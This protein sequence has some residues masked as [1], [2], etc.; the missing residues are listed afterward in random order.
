MIPACKVFIDGINK[1]SAFFD[2][3]GACLS[4]LKDDIS[5]T[6]E[7]TRKFHFNTVKKEAE[8]VSELCN[9]FF[10]TIPKV[11]MELSSIPEMSVSKAL[12]RLEDAKAWKE[13]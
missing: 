6:S 8:R 1:T 7:A 11:N 2:K 4:L 12:V 13:L 9:T 5:S 10:D 3:I